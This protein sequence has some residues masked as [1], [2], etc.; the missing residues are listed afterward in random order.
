MRE[1]KKMCNFAVQKGEIAL[2]LSHQLAEFERLRLQKRRSLCVVIFCVYTIIITHY[3][4]NTNR[5]ARINWKKNRNDIRF[6]CRR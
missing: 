4:Y 1:I 3:L 6:Q 5:N 2:T